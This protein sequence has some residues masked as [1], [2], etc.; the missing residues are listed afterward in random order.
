MQSASGEG[1]KS[2]PT[3]QMSQKKT[4]PNASACMVKRRNRVQTTTSPNASNTHGEK[5]KQSLIDVAKEDVTQCFSM[6]GEKEKPRTNDDVTQCLKHA[7]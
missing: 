6:H 5:V 2:A 4:S 3:G 7:W 1:T